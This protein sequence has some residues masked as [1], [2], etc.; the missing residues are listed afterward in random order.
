MLTLAE[1]AAKYVVMGARI[2]P[3]KPGTK[4]PIG[5]LVPNGYQD[6]SDNVLD[7]IEWWQQ[8]PDANIGVVP[9]SLGALVIDL[10]RGVDPAVVAALPAPMLLCE[11][12]SGGA[13]LWYKADQPYGSPKPWPNT[14]LRCAA[15]YVLLPPSKID[16]RDAKAALDQTR[17]GTYQWV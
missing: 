13:H 1:A 15:G 5:A 16:E 7:V 10:D 12:P 3:C 8:C 4:V 6:A 9:W 2:F 11:S 17:C 14:D